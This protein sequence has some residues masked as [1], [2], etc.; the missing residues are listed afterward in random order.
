MLVPHAFIAGVF[1]C[2]PHQF[3]IQN[4]HIC[5]AA[6]FNIFKKIGITKLTLNDSQLMITNMIWFGSFNFK[7]V[8]IPPRWSQPFTTTR[9]PVIH[10]SAVLFLLPPFYKNASLQQSFFYTQVPCFNSLLSKWLLPEETHQCEY[11]DCYGN[12]GIR[13]LTESHQ[14]ILL[15]EN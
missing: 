2:L 15:I 8:L 6:S 7:I 12:A 4:G 11:L 13:S 5:L 14:T 3:Y 10:L 1:S 9:I